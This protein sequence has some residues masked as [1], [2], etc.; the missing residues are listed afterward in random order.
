VRSA[1][2]VERW[3]Q[4]GEQDRS[5]QL[6]AAFFA[7]AAFEDGAG[8]GHERDGTPCVLGFGDVAFIEDPLEGIRAKCPVS[9]NRELPLAHARN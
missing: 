1:P 4:A 7:H 8:G 5:M 3:R 6:W 2:L 9:A